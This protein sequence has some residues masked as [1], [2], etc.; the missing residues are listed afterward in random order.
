MTPLKC[1]ETV[2][3]TEFNVRRA[4]SMPPLKTHSEELPL[5]KQTLSIDIV[6]S[7]GSVNSSNGLK[8]RVDNSTTSYTRGQNILAT[9][10]NTKFQIIVDIPKLFFSFAKEVAPSKTFILVW[11]SYF[12]ESDNRQVWTWS[13]FLTKHVQ[14]E[15]I[16]RKVGGGGG[17]LHLFLLI[18]M[19]RMCD[20]SPSVVR[21][22]DPFVRPSVRL[23]F[24]RRSL[25]QR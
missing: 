16:R 22:S 3:S 25:M 4:A 15:N 6:W 21:L 2:V 13:K 1:G 24:A 20:R 18:L 8:V 19:G 14:L 9:P 17:W 10:P 5:S 7:L 23:F 11:K 12:L